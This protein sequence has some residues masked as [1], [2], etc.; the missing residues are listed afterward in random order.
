MLKKGKYIAVRPN[1]LIEARYDLT[2]N[3]ND[4]LDMVLSKIENDDSYLYELNINDYKR[5]YKNNT[6]NIYRDFKKAVKEFEGDGFY[7][8]DNQNKKEIF[9]AWFASILYSDAEGKVVVEIGQRLKGLLI[10]MKKRIYYKIE[11][12]LNFNSIYSKRIYYYLKSFEDTGWRIDNLDV[13][14]KKLQCPKSYDKYGLFRAKV[15]DMAYKEINNYSDISFEFEPIK[16]GRKVTNIKFI[17][18][19]NES[20]NEIAA[21]KVAKAPEGMESIEKV[22]SIMYGHEITSLEAKKIYDSSEGDFELIEKV[23]KDFKNKQVG[24]FV[25]AMISMVKPGVYNDPKGNDKKT[26]FNDYEQRSY[27]YNDLEKK[28]L[29]W[30]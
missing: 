13:L 17:I 18:S 2:S 14:R 23:Y 8:I 29:G 28:L 24:N 7:L 10:E 19:S 26:K 15:L 11:Y 5:L 6:S 16:T 20:K 9:F 27:D 25:G 22:K 21:T 12:P 3:Q 1:T 4:I 30:K